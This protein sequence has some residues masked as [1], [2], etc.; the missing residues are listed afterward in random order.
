MSLAVMTSVLTSALLLTATPISVTLEPLGFSVYLPRPP[1]SSSMTREQ[2]PGGSRRRWRRTIPS[3]GSTSCSTREALR[4][5]ERKFHDA[6]KDPCEKLPSTME[7]L[8]APPEIEWASAEES[9]HSFS[10]KVKGALAPLSF[11]CHTP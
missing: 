4:S 10:Y 8:K 7:W 3:N 11:S 1:W 9:G 2:S 6:W 5:F